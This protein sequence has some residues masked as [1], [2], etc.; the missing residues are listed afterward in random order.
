MANPVPPGL[1]GPWRL[2]ILDGDPH[3]PKWI[4]ATVTTPTDVR[5][6]VIG[7]GGVF[8]ALAEARRWVRD[9][10]GRPTVA[11]VPLHRPEVWQIDETPAEG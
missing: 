6:A 2:L 1:N 4:V 3:D 5:P 7:G 9:L 8:A 11:L 10:L